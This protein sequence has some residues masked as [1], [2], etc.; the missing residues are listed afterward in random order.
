MAARTSA[1]RRVYLSYLPSPN[2]AAVG[3]SVCKTRH[4]T[5]TQ[6]V[7]DPLRVNM[8]NKRNQNHI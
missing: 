6:H 3:Q 1:A 7:I 5:D 8:E 2:D 4:V